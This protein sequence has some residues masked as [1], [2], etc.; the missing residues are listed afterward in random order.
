MTPFQAQALAKLLGLLLFLA[1]TTNVL[2]RDYGFQALGH[3]NDNQFHSLEYETLNGDL[4]SFDKFKG[5]VVMITN[6]ASECGYTAQNYRQL[7]QLEDKFQDDFEIVLLP[8]NDFGQQEPGTPDEIRT[9]INDQGGQD[10]TVLK[11]SKVNGPDEHPLMQ[12][13]KVS[14]SVF[15]INY[16]QLN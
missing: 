4:V 15:I 16:Q 9:F 13:L 5:K 2:G 10:Y 1:I 3:L 14:I 8:S 7:R 11:R 6:V 12:L